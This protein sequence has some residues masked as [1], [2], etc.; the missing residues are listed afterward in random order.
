MEKFRMFFLETG[1]NPQDSRINTAGFLLDGEG[2]NMTER[3]STRRAVST[4]EETIRE[5]ISSMG[6]EFIKSFKDT[7][8]VTNVYVRVYFYDT[9]DNVK[10]TEKVHINPNTILNTRYTEPEVPHKNL[11]PYEFFVVPISTK[12]EKKSILAY[13]HKMYGKEAYGNTPKQYDMVHLLSSKDNFEVFSDFQRLSN[14]SDTWVRNAIYHENIRHIVCAGMN[15][16]AKTMDERRHTSTMTGVRDYIWDVFA[17]LK[18]QTL[19][20][21]LR[22]NNAKSAAFLATFFA[23]ARQDQ[24]RRTWVYAP[25]AAQHD[26][27]AMFRDV[28][29]VQTYKHMNTRYESKPNHDDYHYARKVFD[30]VLRNMDLLEAFDVGESVT[31]ERIIPRLGNIYHTLM[32]RTEDVAGEKRIAHDVIESK[33]FFD[34][35]APIYKELNDGHIM[36]IR[37]GDIDQMGKSKGADVRVMS[38]TVRDVARGASGDAER[39]R[40]F[41]KMSQIKM[42]PELRLYK[43]LMHKPWRMAI[44]SVDPSTVNDYWDDCYERDRVEWYVRG[45]NK[46]EAP[47]YPNIA[48]QDAWSAPF[49]HTPIAVIDPS[50][51]KQKTLKRANDKVEKYIVDLRKIELA[52]P[53]ENSKFYKAFKGTQATHYPMMLRE[54]V[55]PMMFHHTNTSFS[56]KI[57]DHHRYVNIY[58][59]DGRSNERDILQERLANPVV[60]LSHNIDATTDFMMDAVVNG[61]GQSLL[62]FKRDNDIDDAAALIL[63]DDPASVIPLGQPSQSIIPG[64]PGAAGLAYSPYEDSNRRLAAVADFAPYRSKFEGGIRRAYQN[65]ASHGAQF[66]GETSQP[67]LKYYIDNV[68]LIDNPEMIRAIDVFYAHDMFWEVFC[69]TFLDTVTNEASM[70]PMKNVKEKLLASFEGRLH[71]NLDEEIANLE[72][73]EEN[74]IDN[75]T[76]IAANKQSRAR[77]LQLVLDRNNTKIYPWLRT[78]LTHRLFDEKICTEDIKFYDDLYINCKQQYLFDENDIPAPAIGFHPTAF[79]VQHMR[80]THVKWEQNQAVVPPVYADHP[81]PHVPSAPQVMDRDAHANAPS[82]WKKT[83]YRTNVPRRSAK[84]DPYRFL[85]ENDAE[86]CLNLAFDRPFVHPLDARQNRYCLVEFDMDNLQS[87]L[88]E[89][90]GHAIAHAAAMNGPAVL[91]VRTEMPTGWVAMPPNQPNTGFGERMRRFYPN[92]ADVLPLAPYLLWQSS[93]DF[94]GYACNAGNPLLGSVTYQV[95]KDYVGVVGSDV[96]HTSPILDSFGLHPTFPYSPDKF[97]TRVQNDANGVVMPLAFGGP[98]PPALVNAAVNAVRVYLESPW[99]AN[100]QFANDNIDDIVNAVDNVAKNTAGGVDTAAAQTNAR[101]HFDGAR[102]GNTN[103]GPFTL[104]QFVFNSVLNAVVAP[105]V[106]PA[107]IAASTA[108]LAATMRLSAASFAHAI[109]LKYKRDYQTEMGLAMLRIVKGDDPDAAISAMEAPHLPQ[110]PGNRPQGVRQPRYG[111]Y[112]DHHGLPDIVV[113]TE[114]K[115]EQH[116]HIKKI[117]LAQSRNIR[118]DIIDAIVTD[119]QRNGFANVSWYVAEQ[120]AIRFATELERNYMKKIQPQAVGPQADFYWREAVDA[121]NDPNQ[122]VVQLGATKHAQIFTLST[123]YTLRLLDVR[124]DN[125]CQVEYVPYE[126]D[127]STPMAVPGRGYPITIRLQNPRIVYIKDWQMYKEIKNSLDVNDHRDVYSS[128]DRRSRLKQYNPGDNP[129]AMQYHAEI[130]NGFKINHWIDKGHVKTTNMKGLRD[131]LMDAFNRMSFSLPNGVESNMVTSAHTASRYIPT[132]ELREYMKKHQ[133]KRV[134]RQAII[135]EDAIDKSGACAD[136]LND[137]NRMANH[138]ER[139]NI[140]FLLYDVLLNN[141]PVITETGDI[142]IK[143]KYKDAGMTI[144]ISGNIYAR[145]YA[146]SIVLDVGYCRPFSKALVTTNSSSVGTLVSG[147]MNQALESYKF[148]RHKECA[149]KSNTIRDYLK[150]VRGMFHDKW[151]LYMKQYNDMLAKLTQT[152]K[153]ETD[154]YDREVERL[155]KGFDELKAAR[156]AEGRNQRPAQL[157]ETTLDNLGFFTVNEDIVLTSVFPAAPGSYFYQKGLNKIVIDWDPPAN[158]P[159]YANNNIPEVRLHGSIVINQLRQWVPAGPFPATMVFP[160]A[161]GLTPPQGLVEFIVTSVTRPDGTDLSQT[162][163]YNGPPPMVGTTYQLI[164]RPLPLNSEYRRAL[165]FHVDAANSLPNLP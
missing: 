114:Q 32:I 64:P 39:R 148:K 46:M 157:I 149:A 12:L 49:K 66:T 42:N 89:C 21:I 96:T 23:R 161:A 8:A 140:M 152:T 164:N 90:K 141:Q 143:P 106:T 91:P 48:E 123:P 36:D 142:K 3:L 111:F 134:A 67:W 29:N 37:D 153:S 59:Y 163:P 154:W 145:R 102:I 120:A 113:T 2:E 80:L 28:C 5:S 105:P 83:I 74:T 104:H 56:A 30:D 17:Y 125:T 138:N 103:A 55:C 88:D 92:L 1:Q 10:T 121:V 4:V 26:S 76:L 24:P 20:K 70:R 112:Y 162:A 11:E 94:P 119:M 156:T 82:D 47:Q 63:D 127:Q 53:D 95:F 86:H 50:I 147:V 128:T 68:G 144:D 60:A 137:W 54:K 135:M 126:L 19:F 22:Y 15:A 57:L 31:I 155:R 132:S 51:D 16:I 160:G 122:N 38:Q 146:R 130:Q 40:Y 139:D 62:N 108:P 18:A 52:K 107:Q 81:N 14:N 78:D 159:S 131:N 65:L 27:Y 6:D 35:K 7:A 101:L 71:A 93:I 109:Y 77:E 129:L 34:E 84:D 25:D 136:P 98:P 116:A 150:D 9:V 118:N 33:L 69:E 44:D 99:T 124:D 97:Y 115:N 100:I 73:I 45:A 79:T 61:K 165:E 133:I 13:F 117:A 158:H 75:Q 72:K 110:I 87:I 58:D 151:N 43:E 85:G 41:R